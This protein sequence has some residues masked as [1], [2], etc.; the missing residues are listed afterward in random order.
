MPRSAGL[1]RLTLTGGVAIVRPRLYI[2]KTDNLHRRLAGNYRNP[3]PTQQTSLRINATLTRHL[4]G[5]GGVALAAAARASVW[6][7]GAEGPLDLSSK[8]VRLLAQ[9]AAIVL[10]R[11][12]ADAEIL[13][14]G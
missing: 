14:L 3:D 10:A 12:A 11:T 5:G 13:N 4:A 2:A 1:Y 7:G 8:A 9:S 6:L